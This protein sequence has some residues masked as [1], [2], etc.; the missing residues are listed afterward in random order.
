MVAKAS[1]FEII[2]HTQLLSRHIIPT[3][4]PPSSIR[5]CHWAGPSSSPKILLL[6]LFEFTQ[7]TPWFLDFLNAFGKNSV[8]LHV[9]KTL[10]PKYCEKLDASPIFTMET[11]AVRQS[12]MLLMNCSAS[13]C[14]NVTSAY[15]LTLPPEAALM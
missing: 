8:F 15:S 10:Y 14:L 1:K 6:N 5:R 4:L 3:F 12:G 9:Q 7:R 13:A 2:F 11:H